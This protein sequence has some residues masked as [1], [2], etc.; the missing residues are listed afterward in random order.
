MHDVAAFLPK[1]V[2]ALYFRIVMC[3]HLLSVI[4]CPFSH[5]NRWIYESIWRYTVLTLCASVS[6][7][8]TSQY[9]T[10]CHNI[11]AITIVKSPRCLTSR[12]LTAAPCSSSSRTTLAWPFSAAWCSA[13]CWHVS[14]KK[15]KKGAIYSSQVC[16]ITYFLMRVSVTGY[17]RVV[18]WIG[19]TYH[20]HTS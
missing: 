15:K 2:R 10:M 5:K 13:V 8:Y 3:V 17:I 11:Y 12:L 7:E 14:K 20:I 16:N 1:L 18:N 6:R 19:L 9:A 4:T